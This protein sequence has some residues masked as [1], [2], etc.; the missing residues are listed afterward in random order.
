MDALK[1]V[2]DG[3][4]FLDTTRCGLTFKAMNT[5]MYSLRVWSAAPKHVAIVAK[6]GLRTVWVWPR[7]LKMNKTIGHTI[8]RVMAKFETVDDNVCVCVCA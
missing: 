3:L 5:G 7:R 8:F 2:S 4:Y 1:K 6:T